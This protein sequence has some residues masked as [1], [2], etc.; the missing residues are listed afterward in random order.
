[1]TYTFARCVCG[2]REDATD[3][4]PAGVIL[5]QHIPGCR[6]EQRELLVP[7]WSVAWPWYN[8]EESVA[9]R[10]GGPEPPFGLEMTWRAIGSHDLGDPFSLTKH[11]GMAKE[12]YLF[13]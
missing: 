8:S 10:A 3:E 7:M 5:R 13:P 12:W 11:G 9:W 2:Y 1:V 6:Y 4:R